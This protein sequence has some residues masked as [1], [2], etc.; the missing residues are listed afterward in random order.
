MP[1]IHF[2]RF[3]TRLDFM[4]YRQL[5]EVST[6]ITDA[7]HEL[8]E[9]LQMLCLR[10]MTTLKTEGLMYV[11]LDRQGF[12]TPQSSFG[13]TLSTENGE[14][15]RFSISEQTPFTDS[16]RENRIVW[17][18]TLP[19]LP[20]S[21]ASLKQINFPRNLKTL[22]TCP[23]EARGLPVGCLSIFSTAKLSYEESIAQ[24]LEAIS[25]ILASALLTGRS[26]S[27][28]HLNGNSHT[29]NSNLRLD[30]YSLGLQDYQEPLSERQNLILKLI[31]EGRTNAAIADVL[32]YSESLI[33]QETI[34]IYAK[35][36]CSGRNEASQ[37]YLR[38]QANS[39][40]IAV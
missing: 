10:A 6:Y 15:P 9:V 34:K 13:V 37:I 29:S 12:A 2:I 25:M 16:I 22:I 20:K 23:V 40:N 39:A 28:N 31:A 27:Q 8:H 4:L 32:G 33:R 24:Y 35:L 18:D 11:E 7:T 1:N 21:Y 19:Q 5:A 26:Q 36:G 38:N 14:T 30:D 17:I 3:T